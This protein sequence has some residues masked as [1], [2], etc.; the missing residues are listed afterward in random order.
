MLKQA[1]IILALVATVALPF[2]LRPAQRALGKADD[3]LVIITPHNEA[4]RFEFGRGFQ[5]WYRERTGRTVSV[6]WRVVG[7]TSEI[8][9]VIEG[10]YHAA[11]ERRWTAQAGRRWSAEIQAGY[12]QPDLPAAASAE[13]RAARAEFLASDVGCGIDLFFGGGSYDFV[14]QAQAGRIVPSRVRQTHPE[15]FSAAVI[16]RTFTGEQFWDDEGCWVG[17]VISSYGILY[18]ADALARLNL[19]PPTA[20]ADLGGAGYLGALALCDP[21]KSSSM[22]KAFENIVQQEIWRFERAK[23]GTGD[24][25]ERTVVREGWT[26]G[27]RVVQR[28]A[29]NARYFTDSSQKPPIDVAQGDCAA[30][31]CIDFYGRAQ[32]EAVASRG[33]SRLGFVTPRGGTVNSV[34]PIALLRGAPHREVAERF[35]EYTLTPEAQKL[36]NFK[37]G[38][39]GG[40][41]R[42]ALRRLPVR[43]DFY[44]HTE[45]KTLRSDPDAAPFA[46]PFPLVY[47]PEWTGHL[48]RELALVVRVMGLDSHAELKAAMRAINAVRA[49]DGPRAEAALAKLADV[50]AVDYEQV[51]G[52]IRRTLRAKNKVDEVRLTTELGE[53][54]RRQYREAEA[55][56]RGEN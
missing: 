51:N 33:V 30:G 28:I 41:E 48:I 9:R 53:R 15:W 44:E 4:T 11:F 21:T 40:P 6:D 39:A 32:A 46:D 16:P 52:L 10:A 20:W 2:A 31:I 25:A 36:W 23:A 12:V 18:N 27:L 43:R 34:D 56:A 17:N 7:G 49:T 37:P 47:R 45:W 1:C 38:T 13:V 3:T 19:S 24:A 55:I 29:A 5:A 22:A 35:I 14:R 54:F 42:F 26:E 50:G 8:A